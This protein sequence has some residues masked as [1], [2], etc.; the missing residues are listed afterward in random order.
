MRGAIMLFLIFS[1]LLSFVSRQ[2]K[3][4][5]QACNSKTGLYKFLLLLTNQITRHKLITQQLPKHFPQFPNRRLPSF[6]FNI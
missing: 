3:V 1:L 6:R 2:K 5:Q 4:R